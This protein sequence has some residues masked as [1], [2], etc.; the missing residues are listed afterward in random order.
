MIIPI[1]ASILTFILIY[2]SLSVVKLRMKHKVSLGDGGHEDLHRAIRAHGNFVETALW[3]IFMLFLLEYQDANVF[4]LHGLGVLLV[5]GRVL[6][7]QAIKSSNL[8][9]RKG[10]MVATLTVFAV[11]ALYNLYLAF[12]FGV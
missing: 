3:G 10:G 4:V 6:H 1:Y 12:T 7:L 5:A 11:A 9:L 8:T 2:L